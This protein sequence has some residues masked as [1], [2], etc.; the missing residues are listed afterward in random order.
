[1]INSNFKLW[2]VKFMRRGFEPPMPFGRCKQPVFALNKQQA[3]EKVKNYD[4]VSNYYKITA[5][6]IQNPTEKQINEAIKD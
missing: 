6:V 3:I 2:I 5:S 1:M 4:M